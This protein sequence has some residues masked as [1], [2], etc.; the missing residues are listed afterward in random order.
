[1]RFSGQRVCY[2]KI[3]NK[4]SFSSDPQTVQYCNQMLSTEVSWFT[5]LQE[6]TLYFQQ[7]VRKKAQTLI[8][9]LLSA[10]LT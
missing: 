4:G 10:K 3:K 8:H 5:T 6:E 2:N 1:M 9:T 7:S